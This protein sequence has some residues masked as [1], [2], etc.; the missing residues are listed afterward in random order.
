MATYKILMTVATFKQVSEMEARRIVREQLQN[1][2]PK[3]IDCK[4]IGKPPKQAI[5]F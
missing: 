3:I 4:L 2:N 5:A 1:L